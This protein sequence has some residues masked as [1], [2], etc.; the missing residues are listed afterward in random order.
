LLGVISPQRLTQLNLWLYSC[1]WTTF[2]KL[3]ESILLPG[4]AKTMLGY[5]FGDVWSCQSDHWSSPKLRVRIFT[6]MVSDLQF[7]L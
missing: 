7:F 5:E 6:W 3:N 2:H 4:W 1:C